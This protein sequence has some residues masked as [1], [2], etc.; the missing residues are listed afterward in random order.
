MFDS[1]RR[2]FMKRTAGAVAAATI[3]AT[4]NRAVADTAAQATD[5]AACH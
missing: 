4:A 5:L 3:G 2:A 1:N